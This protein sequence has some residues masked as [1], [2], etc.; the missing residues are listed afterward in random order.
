[1][2]NLCDRCGAIAKHTFCKGDLEISLCQHHT[3]AHRVALDK[4]GFT[5]RESRKL[6]EAIR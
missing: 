3:N 4:E 2:A 5:P 1:M 6:E